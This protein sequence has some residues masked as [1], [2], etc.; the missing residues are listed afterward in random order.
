MKGWCVGH[1]DVLVIVWLTLDLQVA[2]WC[3]F[4]LC[5]VHLNL[6]LKWH[7]A[8]ITNELGDPTARYRWDGW[9]WE[10]KKHLVTLLDRTPICEWYI[11][12]LTIVKNEH[13]K[14][15]HMLRWEWTLSSIHI[16]YSISLETHDI[17]MSSKIILDDLKI[18]FLA[19]KW[20]SFHLLGTKLDYIH[21]QDF[22]NMNCELYLKQP[23]TPP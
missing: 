13:Q 14:S 16:T 22:W 6:A 21:L 15:V 18:A 9:V 8:S 17:P 2:T 19:N 5:R 20:N 3:K 23:L 4:R 10:I 12:K 1:H 11:W 7:L